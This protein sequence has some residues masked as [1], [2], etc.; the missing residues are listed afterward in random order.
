MIVQTV[1]FL[2]TQFFYRHGLFFCLFLILFLLIFPSLLPLPLFLNPSFLFLA[3]SFCLSLL[4][5]CSYI[6]QH[7]SLLSVCS[8]LPSPMCNILILIPYTLIFLDKNS[9]IRKRFSFFYF[10]FSTFYYSKILLFF[11]LF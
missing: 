9:V 10:R 8:S 11:F 7:I 6:S 3:Q 4:L 2:M 5:I 1:R